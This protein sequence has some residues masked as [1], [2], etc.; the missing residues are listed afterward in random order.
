MINLR[1][2]FRDKRGRIDNRLVAAFGWITGLTTI[3]LTVL[4]L[5]ALT[6]PTRLYQL[7][8]LDVDYSTVTKADVISALTATEPTLTSTAVT[9]TTQT[10]A[11]TIDTAA[12]TSIL[13]TYLASSFLYPSLRS[14]LW[15]FCY[16]PLQTTPAY[17]G[18]YTLASQQVS[19]MTWCATPTLPYGFTGE[20]LINKLMA[21]AGATPESAAQL[22]AAYR[23]SPAV[24]GVRR[25]DAA[26][27]GTTTASLL[28][29]LLGA[30]LAAAALGLSL[31]V[32]TGRTRDRTILWLATA[33]AVLL[34]SA[35]LILSV[36]MA[37]YAKA[38]NTHLGAAQ[39][40][41]YIGRAV[42]VR[43]S[44]GGSALGITWGAAA[45]GGLSAGAWYY[46]CFQF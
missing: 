38:I 15:N 35:A 20:Q 11:T 23:A 2:G 25:H 17:Y 43:A 13:Q 39:A 42:G 34:F 30:G 33:A 22:V 26:M 4:T 32:F 8:Y 10:A 9:P 44:V 16:G 3:I 6:S 5:I 36:T 24:A 40:N 29:L 45:C 28:C 41:A 37:V 46:A 12:V 21:A 31:F 7:S 27:L 18:Y 19:G 14:H 1:N